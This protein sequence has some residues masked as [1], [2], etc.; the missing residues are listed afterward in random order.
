MASTAMLKWSYYNGEAGW[1]RIPDI[2]AKASADQELIM[3]A[4]CETKG[5]AYDGTD[6]VGEL[7]DT[8]VT[9]REKT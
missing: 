8:P 1:G 7:D 2:I 6:C 3:A 5:A 4:I 9:V